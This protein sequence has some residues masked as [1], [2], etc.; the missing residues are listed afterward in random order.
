M[1][2]FVSDWME[3]RWKDYVAGL[4]EKKLVEVQF[5]NLNLKSDFVLEK[6]VEKKL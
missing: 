4:M 2:G 3:I 6:L 5:E 1:E